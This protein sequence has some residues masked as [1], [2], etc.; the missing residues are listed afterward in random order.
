MK[1]IRM[2]AL[3]N[4]SNRLKRVLI[5]FK[6]FYKS[7]KALGILYRAIEIEKPSSYADVKLPPGLEVGAGYIT[8]RLR[9][10]VEKHLPPKIN[11]GKIQN[12]LVHKFKEYVAELTH[13][14]HAHSL[15]GDA[16]ARLDEQELVL[17]TLMATSNQPRQRKEKVA[18]AKLH[19]RNLVKL[20]E[21]HFGEL[22]AESTKEE[23]RMNMQVAWEAWKFSVTQADTFGGPSFGLIALGSILRLLKR[24]SAEEEPLGVMQPESYYQGIVELGTGEVWDGE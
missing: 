18:T 23:M 22:K 24:L 4:S 7:D 20:T 1:R 16:M 5:L 3:V 13:I 19:M 21:M 2:T 14:A 9:P 11:M 15:S 6:A 12:M 10:L 17:G 8:K